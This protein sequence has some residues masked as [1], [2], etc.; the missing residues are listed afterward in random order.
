MI[1][2]GSIAGRSLVC[3][4]ICIASALRELFDKEEF[5]LDFFGKGAFREANKS[6]PATLAICKNWDFHESGGL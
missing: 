3:E 2:L 6:S 5:H 1:V 4:C